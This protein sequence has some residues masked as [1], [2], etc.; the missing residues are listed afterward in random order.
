V[1]R[2]LIGAFIAPLA[3]T[4]TFAATASGAAPPS[5]N[6][7]SADPTPPSG[8][9]APLRVEGA[10]FER[11]RLTVAVSCDEDGHVRVEG[12][13]KAGFRCADGKGVAQLRLARGL[14]SGKLRIDARSSSTTVTR[15]LRP[16]RPSARRSAVSFSIGATYWEPMGCTNYRGWLMYRGAWTPWNTTTSV[17]LYHEIANDTAIGTWQDYYYYSTAGTWV[18][19]R[20]RRCY[21]GGS[22]CRWEWAMAGY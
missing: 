4:F 5:P 7:P 3:L 8:V 22:E 2:R 16:T 13:G 15:S 17:C 18:R 19:Y 11:H 10:T 14:P 20:I 21:A 9:R 12:V 1:Q 6:P